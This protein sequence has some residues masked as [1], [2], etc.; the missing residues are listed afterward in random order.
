MILLSCTKRE[1]IQYIDE[2]NISNKVYDAYK[3][4]FNQKTKLSQIKSWANSLPF[5]KEVLE[6]IP[7]DAGIAIEYGIPLSNKR[8]DVVISGYDITYRPVILIIELKQWKYA[9]CVKDQDACVRTRIGKTEKNVIHP[10]YQVL[11]Y[12]ELLKNY[13]PV[14]ENQDIQI[15]PI[16]YL[17]N[18][19]FKENDSLYE[20]K[21]RP[22]YKKVLMYGKNEIDELKYTIEN[23][24]CFGDNLKIINM[25]QH[26][27]VKPLKKLTDAL[28]SMIDTKKEYYLLDE[29]KVILEEIRRNVIDSY[30]DHKKRVILIKGGPGT[31]KS[32]LAIKALSELLKI[33]LIGSYVSK[34]MAPRNVYKSILSK[35]NPGI[36]VH[37]FFKTSSY[38]FRDFDNKYDFLLV[39][40]AHRLQEKSGL[41]HHINENQIKAAIRTSR[42][43]IF[44]VDEKQMITLKDVGTVSNIYHFA[45][46]FDA[47]IQEYELKSQ[48]RCQG[49]NHYLD[50]IESF[51]YNKNEKVNFHFDFQI[52][53]SPNKLYELIK[54]K[55][56]SNNARL[57]AGFCWNRYSKE[58]DNQNYH[59]IQLKDFS[60]SWNL[61]HG[62]EFALRENAIHEVGCVYNVQGLEFDYIG[63]I[64][65]PDL[66]Y[67]NRRVCTDYTKRAS[68]EKS[69]YGL[70]VLLKENKEKYSKV[71]DTIIRNTYLVLLTRGIK[72][73]YVYAC[74]EKLQEHLKRIVE[75][76]TIP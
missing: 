4:I 50:F 76:H 34:N 45:N 37:E 17:H 47:D 68:T 13:N 2:K 64:I 16:V 67:R 60:L 44:F 74:D 75:N 21:Y 62:E 39:D 59:D 36:L 23:Y 65:G 53:D 38:L 31:G 24:I 63:V 28:T 35:E 19:E 61:K 40:E 66:I 1:F 3:N 25:T 43:C 14:I 20:S 46:L 11:S 8:I 52:L 15:I 32:V 42:C 22:Y 48:F 56:T 7:D 51:L 69:L 33:G 57:V 27:D 26:S 49:S 29:Q 55:N 12:K 30:T 41:R 10:A 71:A 18:Y 73:C 54:Q 5:L 58:A 70:H 9:K 72:G 6:A